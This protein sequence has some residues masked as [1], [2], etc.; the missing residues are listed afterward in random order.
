MR[1]KQGIAIGSVLLFFSGMAEASFFSDLAGSMVVS[2]TEQ[3]EIAKAP[4]CKLSADDALVRSIE[5]LSDGQQ[6]EAEALIKSA[7][8]T[9][10][11]D[12]RILFA[13]GV[14]ERSRWDKL[15]ADV[16]FA[17]ARRKTDNQ[18]L[19]RAAWLST[20]LDRYREPKKNLAELIRLSDENPDDIYLLWLGAIQC[21]EQSRDTSP[22]SQSEKTQIAQMGKERYRLLLS[23]FELG[24]VMVHHTYANILTEDTGDYDEALE[25]RIKALSMSAKSWTLEGFADTLMEM[26]KYRWACAVWA[27]AVKRDGTDA[28]FYNRWG[29]A[30]Y[31]LG[32]YREAEEKYWEAIRLRPRKGF[33]WNDLADCLEKQGKRNEEMFKAYQRAVELGYDWALGNLAWCYHQGLGTEKDETKGFE[34]YLRYQK[35]Y[36][37]SS[38]VSRKIAR[39]YDSGA[40]VEKNAL[41][42]LEYY[43]KAA[44]L[45]PNSPAT[46]NAFAWNLVVCNDPELRDYPRAIELA[47]RSIAANENNNNLDTLAVAYFRNG[48]YGEAVKT[49]KRN[50]EFW[51]EKNPSKPVPKGMLKR[52]KKYKNALE[53]SKEEF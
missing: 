34:L 21:R 3:Q 22:L 43:E 31:A 50:I 19:S 12:V 11:D 28:R 33:Y 6:V 40:G 30:L 36:P 52:L 53:K 4:D 14:L 7:V 5:L 16:W 20:Q 26:E 13:K 24:P 2:I 49:Q 27:Q 25:H 9:H 45:D 29:D 10:R 32:K 15:A 51:T 47:K 48:Q 46:L 23:H 41:K 39:C 35:I 1:L 38:W 8:K 17:Q 37:D 42:A 18:V 44:E